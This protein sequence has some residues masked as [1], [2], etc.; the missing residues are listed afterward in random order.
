MNAAMR[1]PILI[2]AALLAL[3]ACSKQDNA[4]GPGGVSVG[5]AK[6]L[7][8]AAAMIEDQRLPA[9][10]IPAP[11]APLPKGQQAAPV[12]QAPAAAPPR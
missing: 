7:D 5:E 8:E 10:A 4:P 9:D 11:D 6:A 3:A 12:K 2:A 1:R